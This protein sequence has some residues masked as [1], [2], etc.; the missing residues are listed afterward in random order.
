MRISYDP[1]KHYKTLA[2]RGLNFDDAGQVFA[3]NHLTVTDDRKDYGE[4]RY[5]T[6][7]HIASRMVVV[8]WTPRKDSRRIVSMRRANDREQKIYAPR[9]A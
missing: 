5:I 1:A 3:G 4:P 9:L 8:V 2:E 7:G 6:I